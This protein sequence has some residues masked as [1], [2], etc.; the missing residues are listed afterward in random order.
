MNH[1]DKKKLIPSIV[2][3]KRKNGVIIQ[4]C[5]IY[6]GRQCNMGGWRLEKSKWYNPF[7]ISSCGSAENA[8]KKYEE[9]I[10]NNEKLMKDLPELF[11]KKLGCWCKPSI[12]HGDILVKLAKELIESSEY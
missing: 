11:G 4:D 9:Y 7:S 3:I 2:R 6:I 5:D 10:I 1:S 12:C 8:V